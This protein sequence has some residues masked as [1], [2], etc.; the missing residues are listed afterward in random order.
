[1]HDAQYWETPDQLMTL[2]RCSQG[3]IHLRVG[4]AIIKLTQDEFFSLAKLA[5]RAARELSLPK[6]PHREGP[7][8]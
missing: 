1:M 5:D 2:S 8:H 6:L 7:G 3:C 4:R